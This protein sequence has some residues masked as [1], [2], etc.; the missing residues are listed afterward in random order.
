MDNEN[1]DFLQGFQAVFDGQDE[2]DTPADIDLNEDVVES[3]TEEELTAAFGKQ[4][5][6]VVKEPVVKEEDKAQE[7]PNKK[8]TEEVQQEPDT[9]ELPDTQDDTED[10]DPTVTGFFDVLSEKL[11]WEVGDEEKPKTADDLIEYFT[12]A[13]KESSKPQFANEELER[14]N[15]YVANGGEL[16]KYFESQSIIDYDDLDLQDTS[17]Q[18][19]VVYNYLSEQGYNDEQIKNRITRYEEAGILEDEASDGLVYLKAS[20]EK[21]KEELLAKQNQIAEQRLQAQQ[22]KADSVV[23]Q[24]KALDNIRGIKVPEQDKAVLIN[25][26]LKPE[27]DGTSKWAKD[28]S[29]NEVQS[30]VEL[31]YITMK[32][33]TFVKTA[34]NQGASDAV[35]K[36]K[37]SLK[38]NKISGNSKPRVASDNANSIW[39]TVAGRLRNL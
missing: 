2:Q 6:T 26:I 27:A 17:N 16:N 23:A 32:G 33:D 18:K 12:E 29:K 1:M 11:G 4:N 5:P 13:I 9:D 35:S 10:E 28:Y 39:N 37:N 22:Q 3:P 36:F 8:P 20:Q 19:S 34:K 38:S 31:A 21:Q 24:I 7:E 30:L 15:Q 14:L 25:Y